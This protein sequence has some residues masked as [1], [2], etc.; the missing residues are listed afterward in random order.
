MGRRDDLPPLDLV[1]PPPEDRGAPRAA[2]A[3]PLATR[4]PGTAAGRRD[5]GWWRWALAPAVVVA[6]VAGVLVSDRRNRPDP[7]PAAPATTIEPS[8]PAVT[9][10]EVREGRVSVP[11]GLSGTTRAVHPAI[12]THARYES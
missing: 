9:A 1:T 10:P 7:E 2:A 12:A 11:R 6:V 5:D 8:T 3:R 4:R